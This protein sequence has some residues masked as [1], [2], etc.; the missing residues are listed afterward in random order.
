MPT[1][2][3][4][5]IVFVLYDNIGWGDWGV[6]GG[7]TATPRIDEFAG[8]GVRFNN[9]NV[10]SQCTPTRAAC[11]T[12]R[13]PSRSGTYAVPLPG[14]GAY[15]LSPW[16]YTLAELLSDAGYATSAWG[17]WHLG[18]VEGRLPTDQGFDEWWGYRNTID[19]A[20]Y[21]SYAGFREL[22]KDG[23]VE[24]PKIWEAKRGEK[25]V[26]V[27]DLDLAIRPLVDEKIAGLATD[28]IQRK[29]KDGEPFFTYVAFSHVHPPEAAHPDFDQTSPERNG[30]YADIIA[31]TDYRFGQILDAID[32]AGIADNTIVLLLSDNA[33]G[34]VDATL[35]G[36]NGPWHGNFM[37]PPFEGSMRVP[38]MVRWPGKIPAGVVTNELLSAV[39]W[40][41]TLATLAGAA[42]RVPTDRPID[43][44]D[45]SEF[46][47]GNADSTGRESILF[48]GPDGE[49]MS[50]KW[51]DIKVVLRYAEGIGEPI[52][53]PM[54]PHVYDLSSD[55]GEQ[56]N[57]MSE[58][59]DMGWMFAPAF[60]EVGAYLRS[61]AQYPN[62]K[63]GEDFEG[64]KQT[65]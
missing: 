4:P 33:A 39:D 1:T 29:A 32:D 18:E 31:E 60:R 10:E 5:N 12:G 42:D 65:A 14:Q 19:E 36:S 26:A 63:P 57:L 7:T 9:Y 41:S 51:H 59:L 54:F 53:K 16:E 2:E 20:G 49:P 13:L 46:L 23:V 61:V 38:G 3:K 62:T 11:L 44:V 22:V 52:C 48:C 55:P 50:V 35:G 58:K 47:L 25:P 64:Y 34:G 21:S 27:A 45:V 37:T 8:Q 17:K 6:Y 40:F 56:Y 24:Q 28:F 15:G 30:R 43:S